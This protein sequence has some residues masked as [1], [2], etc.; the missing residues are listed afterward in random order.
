[1]VSW[2]DGRPS[3]WPQRERE[4]DVA[5]EAVAKTASPAAKRVKVRRCHGIDA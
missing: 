1:M 5:T 4:E 2:M 3:R